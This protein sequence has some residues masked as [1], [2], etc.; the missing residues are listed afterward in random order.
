MQ[1]LSCFLVAILLPPVAL[2]NPSRSAPPP[3]PFPN[4][5]VDCHVQLPDRDVRLST[6]MKSWSEG[7]PPALLEKARQVAPGMQ[8]DGTHPSVATAMSD[9]PAACLSC[10]A[11]KAKTAPPLGALLHAIHLAGGEKNH[12]ITLFQ[13]SCNHC[14]KTHDDGTLTVA[15][16]AERP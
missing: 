6:T 5:C 16:G 1:F 8:L 7:V 14:H 12:Y 10:H 2:A 13:G 4:G 9:V 3:D 11:G 15:N